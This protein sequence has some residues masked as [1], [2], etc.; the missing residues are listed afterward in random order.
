MNRARYFGL[1]VHLTVAGI[2]QLLD[3][4]LVQQKGADLAGTEFLWRVHVEVSE[5]AAVQQVVTDG[6]RTDAFEFEVLFHPIAELT[7]RLRRSH[8]RRSETPVIRSLLTSGCAFRMFF[9]ELVFWRGK[10]YSG[11]YSIETSVTA[12]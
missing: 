3:L 1:R 5:L 7:L 6:S 11:V 4:N 9:R 12:R 10:R 8:C 2:G